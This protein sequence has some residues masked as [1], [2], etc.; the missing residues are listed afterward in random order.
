MGGWL[1][2][3]V[4]V[5]SNLGSEGYITN[6]AGP[7]LEIGS[8]TNKFEGSTTL[9][10]GGYTNSL[11]SGNG[12]SGPL[13]TPAQPL[14]LTGAGNRFD[15]GYWLNGAI[16]GRNSVGSSLSQALPYSS[17]KE[18]WPLKRTTAWGNAAPDSLQGGQTDITKLWTSNQDLWLGPEDVNSSIDPTATANGSLG[19]GYYTDTTAPITMSYTLMPAKTIGTVSGYRVRGNTTLGGNAGV[20]HSSF[21]ATKGTAYFAARLDSAG[22]GTIG[23]I[24]NCNGSNKA[25]IDYVLTTT[26]QVFAY[27]YDAT[28]PSCS[29][30]G[31]YVVF[32]YYATTALPP[33]RWAWQAV[34]PDPE[35]VKGNSLVLNG[36]APITTQVGTGAMVLANTPTLITP[37]IGAATGTSLVLSGGTTTNGWSFNNSINWNQNPSAPTNA[38]NYRS[39]VDA[40]GTYRLEAFDDAYGG[41]NYVYTIARTGTTPTL[42]TFGAPVTVNGALASTAGV[43]GTTGTFSGAVSGTT[44]T[45]SG[46]VSGTAGTFTGRLAGQTTATTGSDGIWTAN[47]LKTD[48]ISGTTGRLIALGPDASTVGGV[49]LLGLSTGAAVSDAYLTCV[50][51]TGCSTPD[52]FAGTTGTFS[53]AMSAS[54]FT[55]TIATGT[56][57]IA[58]TSTTSVANLTLAG[59]TQVTNLVADLA[60]K[61]PVASPTF[62]TQATAPKFIGVIAS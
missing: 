36:G 17:R 56:A 16:F 35:V 44:G 19:V 18:N 1:W 43:S 28:V 13:G 25:R 55:S 57:P 26:W 47:Q 62:T 38:K 59:E 30:V 31:G 7:Y 2:S 23:M 11:V 32:N 46:A 40:S 45:F 5:E 12:N 21:P 34:V 58:V 29:P 42:V 27:P 51:T 9:G 33:V 20:G 54:S 41:G 3:N 24:M 4:Y 14:I 50:H 8:D 52:P 37:V 39:F 53:G 22:S 48:Y 49:T 60:L 61:A 6:Y 15:D 10:G